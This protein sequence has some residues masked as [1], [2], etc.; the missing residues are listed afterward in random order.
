MDEPG[1]A[2]FEYCRRGNLAEVKA[3]LA[4]GVNPN[5]Y[6][7]YDGTTSLLAAARGGHA[8]VVTE[9]VAARADM[10]V[11]TEDG[12][13]ALLHAASGGSAEV[14]AA[15]IKA[16]AKVETTNEDEVTPLLLA[17]HYGHTE[18]VKVLLDGRA[19]PNYSAPGWGG[20]LDAAK[21]DCIALLESRG[22]KRGLEVAEAVPKA[23]EFF[24]YGCLESDT[25]E[26]ALKQYTPGTAQSTESLGS[27]PK[28]GSP[29]VVASTT[30]A[31]GVVSALSRLGQLVKT[32]SASCF[33]GASGVFQLSDG[34][35]DTA[36]V[37]DVVEAVADCATPTATARF[38]QRR[39]VGLSPKTL[40]KSGL[41]ISPVGFGCHRVGV[42]DADNRNALRIALKC[43][44][45]FIDVAPNYTDGAAE[46]AVGDV[47]SE[48]FAAKELRRDEV[49]VS[50]KVG[51]IVGSSLE[52]ESVK[53]MPC[54][55]RVRDDV[56]H[57][58]EPA[59]IEEELT[60]SLD[61]LK[62]KCVDVLLLHCPEFAS[63]AADVD[64]DEVYRR[65]QRA[66][67]HMEEEV[68]RGRIARY[69]V[70]AAF[71]PLRPMDPEHL[72]LDRIVSLLP[73]QHHFEVIQ[74]PLNFA[75][76]QPLYVAHVARDGDGVAL[77][78][79]AS[80]QALCLVEAAR[81]HGLATLTN[82]PLDGLYKE[83]RGVLR[84]SSDVPIN[85]EMQGEDLDG[86]ESK[87]TIMAKGGLGDTS[88]SVTEA[89]A[90]KTIKT[91]ASL[92][93]IDCVLVGMRQ[94]QYVASLVRLLKATPPLD[95]KVALEAVK[96][97]HNTVCIWFCMATRED[98][99]GTAK[100]WRLPPKTQPIAGA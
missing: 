41:S 98:D 89:L 3:E 100:N 6:Y 68:K 75:E 9:L 59:W 79:N 26:A 21:G 44:C 27:A 19:D 81:R 8:E 70:T 66:F 22:A 7:A 74:F 76:P 61:R 50:T 29:A 63:K 87:L 46:T 99:H 90:A 92:D 25:A 4:A 13:D 85:G 18:A 53:K 47:L 52:L 42:E 30:P 60:R 48:L 56:W 23:G 28:A 24:S 64:M 14:I 51:N 45:N 16:G 78:T 37:S 34:K 1:Y 20:A 73:P 80:M 65:I 54:I 2:L 17:A 57:C 82:R 71:Y 35:A 38:M 84:F 39:N 10:E 40:G 33:G 62:L 11:R 36:S 12:S 93:G 15:L 67:L 77:D 83:M 58:I 91:L 97:L 31:T 95:P 5:T 72:L 69:G 86:L 32:V 96:G 43:G 49:V 88:D 55:A 94:V